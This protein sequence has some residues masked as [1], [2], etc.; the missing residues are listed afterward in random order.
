MDA[1]FVAAVITLLLMLLAVVLL[2]PLARWLRLPLPVLL[3]IAGLGLGASAAALD[4]PVPGL[5]EPQVFG[6]LI[7]LILLPTLVFATAQEMDFQR[8]RDNSRAILFLAVPGL[9]ISSGVIALLLGGFTSLSW[10]V[11]LLIGVVLS[12]TDPAAVIEQ[13]KQ[14]GAPRDLTIMVE[15]ESLF[16]DATTIVLAKITLSVL[17]AGGLAVNLFATGGLSFIGALVG[18]AIVGVV[19]AALVLGLLKWLRDDPYTE[20]TLT[21][22]LAYGSYLGAEYLLHASGIVATAAAGLMLARQRPLPVSRRTEQY[23]SHFWGALS[24]IAAGVVFVL[25]GLAAQPQRLVAH[26]DLALAAIIAMLVSRALIIYGLM[27]MAGLLRS[28]SRR[29]ISS[30]KHLLNWGG[31]RGAVTLALAMS[32][33]PPAYAELIVSVVLL[34]VLFTILVQGLSIGWLAHRLGLDVPDT[35][36]RIALNES[37]LLA[38]G[39]ALY[40]LARVEDAVLARVPQLSEQRQR[41]QAECDVLKQQIAHW[42]EEEEGPVDEWR[43]LLLRGL[44]LEVEYLY[45]LFDQGLLPA[46]T[47]IAVRNQLLEL[48][49]GIRHQYAQPDTYPTH[50]IADWIGWLSHLASYSSS[51]AQAQAV[52]DYMSAWA[53]QISATYARNTLH[54]LMQA[55]HVERAVVVEVDTFYNGWLSASAGQIE[56][57]EAA[58][59]DVVAQLR[60]ELLQRQLIAAQIG[61][62]EQQVASGFLNEAQGEALIAELRESLAVE[63]LTRPDARPRRY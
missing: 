23:L 22:L 37:C 36:E 46:D 57:I 47:Y 34:A 31:M 3:V 40:Q 50:R 18:G 14:L 58:F 43:R 48:Q 6:E 26:W 54:Q 20:L 52:A 7:L 44:Y 11:A 35:S 61:S 30:Y 62:L 29:V 45:R 27:P 15:G 51:R 19:L 55:D 8:L 21:L 56:R 39:A 16:N 32:L 63:H 24:F 60:N 9:L 2:A 4:A 28:H 41:L 12:A 25:V 17:T 10:G 13:F 1:P 49:E 5:A 59:P 53:R 42:R 33:A 38:K